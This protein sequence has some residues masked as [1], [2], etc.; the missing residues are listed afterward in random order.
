MVPVVERAR[1]RGPM[2]FDRKD[3]VNSGPDGDTDTRKLICAPAQS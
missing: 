3:C 1:F 2:G